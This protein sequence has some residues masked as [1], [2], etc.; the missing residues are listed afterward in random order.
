MLSLCSR[1]NVSCLTVAETAIVLPNL[2][3]GRARCGRSFEGIFI[4]RVFLASYIASGALRRAAGAAAAAA[5]PCGCGIAPS[6]CARLGGSLGRACAAL[7]AI[8]AH[9]PPP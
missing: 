9:V 5:Q 8:L 4:L 2:T 7:G 3:G 6:R 1:A